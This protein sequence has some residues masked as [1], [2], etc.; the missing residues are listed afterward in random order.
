M[1]NLAKYKRRFYKLRKNKCNIS[2]VTI[3]YHSD[4]ESWNKLLNYII[5]YI[6]KNPPEASLFNGKDE[7]QAEPQT[8]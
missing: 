8:R 5:Q 6:V 1:K 4:V 3:K 7:Q 2:K